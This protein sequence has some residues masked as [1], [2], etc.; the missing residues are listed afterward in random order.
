MGLSVAGIQPGYLPWLGYFDQMRQVDLFVVADEMPF[1]RAGWAHRNRVRAAAGPVWL[2]VPVHAR[3]GQRIDEVGIDHRRRWARGHVRTLEQAY[4]RS[5][6]RDEELP[7]LA[8]ALDA[9]PDRLVD[10]TVPLLRLLAGRLG[11]TTPLVVS[12]D[13]GLEQAYRSRGSAAADP[14]DRIIAF[15]H[16]LGADQ[17]LEGAAGRAYLDVD[18]CRRAGIRVR[19]HDYDHPTYPQL[20]PGFTSHLSVVDLLLTAGAD[21][22]RQ[23]LRTG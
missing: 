2:R 9:T 13:R 10:L 18:R 19:F 21:G 11:I 20:H 8:R 14:T 1:T 4:A 7:A 23:V 17:L 6:H 3:R 16:E 22:A 5:P 15:L 12:S